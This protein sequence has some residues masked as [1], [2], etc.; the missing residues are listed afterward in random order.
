MSFELRVEFSGLCLYLVHSDGKQVGVVMPDCRKT[1][2]DPIHDDDTVGEYHVGY[3]RADLANV[4]DGVPAGDERD[5]P[6]YELI[7]RF[8][9]QVLDFG[10]DVGGDITMTTSP[11]VPSFDGF[12]PDLDPLP[13]LFS[14]TPPKTLLMRTVLRGGSLTGNSEGKGW[15]FARLLNPKAPQYSGDFA[16]YVRWHRWVDAEH[17]TLRVTDFAGAVRTELKLRPV[18]TADG[19]KVVSLKVA[20]LCANNPLEWEGLNLRAVTGDDVDFKWLYRLLSPKAQSYPDVLLGAPLPIPQ[21]LVKGDATGAQD[22][23]GGMKALDF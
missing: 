15:K 6:K 10:L 2:A 8:D 3:V 19:K 23:M 20:N 22:C 14:P 1:T 17:L 5:G 13:G 12:A 18:E 7:H 21:R 16:S 9:R 4:V 11:D